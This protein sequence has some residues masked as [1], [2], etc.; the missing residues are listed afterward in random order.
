MKYTQNLHTHTSFC[1]GKHTPEEIVQK[2]LAQGFTELGFSGHIHT[3]YS[4]VCSAEKTEAYRREVLRLKEA[5][6]DRIDIF[7]GIEY[8][9][10][11]GV[12]VSNGYDYVIAGVHALKIGGVFYPFHRT[13]DVVEKLIA[14]QFGGDAMAYVKCYY[15]TM[16]RLPE[17]GKFDIVA[18][19]DSVTRHVEMK[20][21]FDMESKEYRDMAFTALHA[22]AGKIPFFEVNTGALARGFRTAPYPALPILKEMKRLGVN[23]ILASDA[24][25]GDAL[26][27]GFDP[28][29]ALMREAGYREMYVL[30][31]SGFEAVAL[32]E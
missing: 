5:Y 7:L 25:D 32:E 14:E 3:T 22:I 15:E 21:L 30:K 18:H 6:R 10:Y 27:A 23:L 8:D 31:K 16:A 29:V 4:K 28:A 17:E 11:C 9:M 24:H 19:F 13:L 26:T 1:D 12:D 20:P 2:A